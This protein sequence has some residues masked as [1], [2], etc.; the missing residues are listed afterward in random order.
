MLKCAEV[1]AAYVKVTDC[2]GVFIQV[3]I[4][5]SWTEQLGVFPV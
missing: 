5:T 4:N 1:G 3:I 2:V